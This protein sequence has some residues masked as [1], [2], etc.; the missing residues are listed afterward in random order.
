MAD[1]RENESLGSWIRRRRKA[2][3]LTQAVL[4]QRVGCAEVTIRKLEAEVT[5]P[6]RQI[7]ERLATCLEVPA[8]AHAHF[9][10][11]ARGERSVDDLPP[12]RMD[13]TITP[14]ASADVP[15]EHIPLDV[16][17]LPAPL[18]SGSRMPLRR[19]PL[20]VGRDGA[21][22][23]LARALT[24]SGT[25]AI[26][27]IEIAA[28]TG[29]GGIG[30]TQLACEFV[31]RYGPF[32]AG[33][34]FWLSFAD[35]AAV[36]AEVAACGGAEGMQLSADFGTLSLDTQVQQVL[37]AWASSTPR[38]LVFDNCEDEVLLEQWRPAH[39]G[40]RV[41]LTSRR[42][43]WDAALGVQPLPLDVLHR[44]ES[45]AL[46]CQFRPDL[47]DADADLSAIADALGDL[48]LALHLAGSFLAKYRHALTPA[49]YLAR[50]HAPTLLD[51][52]SLQA[53]GLSPT[54]H[55][56]HVARTFAQSYARLDPADPTDAIARM[57]LA[58]AAYVA[59]GEPIPRWFLLH[60][61]TSTDDPD[62]LLHVEDALTRLLDLGL[63]ETHHTDALRLHRLLVAFVRAVDHD[64]AARRAVQAT[65]L[66]VVA[67]RNQAGNPWSLMALQQHLR[68]IAAEPQEEDVFAA[69][70]Y[71]ALGRYIGLR[72][73]YA[74]AR[75]YIE[76]AVVIQEQLLGREHPDTA[77]S[78]RNLGEI[79]WRQGA[80]GE[81]RR[82]AEQ[83]IAIQEQ[84]LGRE[85]VDTAQSLYTLGWIHWYEGA[86]SEARRCAEQAV[87]IQ[88]RVLGNEHPA[89]AQSLACLGVVLEAQGQYA[90]AQHYLRRALVIQERVLGMEH[91]NT[92]QTL[93]SM[94]G[95][96][97][98]QGDYGQAAHCL[99]RA[100][101]IHQCVLG[102][103]HPATALTLICLGNLQYAQ[104][105]YAD[106][107]RC[108]EQSLAIRQRVLGGNHP[109]I[110][111]SLTKLGM[112]LE[113]KGRYAEAQDYYE[114]ALV[115]FQQVLGVDHPYTA[116]SLN[117]LGSVFESQK[118]YAEAQAYYEQGLAIMERVLGRNHPYTAS[119]L[120]NLGSVFESQKRYA[121]AQDYYEQA[122]AIRQ[123][124][125][126]IDHSDTMRSLRTLG[127]LL[128]AQGN[129]TQARYYLEQAL[130]VFEQRLGSQH[131]DTE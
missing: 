59:P 36:P 5:R 38:L 131:P 57:L 54:Q 68:F 24:M 37:T 100:L 63:L 67:D 109:L 71:S 28:A 56:Q 123:C 127:T 20:F 47:S 105:Q 114:Q 21:L 22:R 80:Y 94:G 30:K 88:E 122:L 49:Q 25:A 61:L 74:E 7:A 72:G 107:H 48:P 119:S 64:T 82:C 118:R 89:I 81:A 73:A 9:L 23:Q 45:V 12:A 6:S 11:V 111:E 53:A 35:P 3:D 31:H 93:I 2:L 106:A 76:R 50:L 84:V 97:T 52:R 13:R 116:S 19:N 129:E 65:M 41:L 77:Q 1:H 17:P 66:Q 120:N 79:L 121:E 58:R 62:A 95:V 15:V 101:E 32:F 70:L 125:L 75:R 91:P 60:T 78:L 46:L 14:S 34:V 99:K 85:H 98:S 130:A 102:T 33:G 43:H 26:G 92:A 83:A 113:A 90:E 44:A 115:L 27:Q 104:A 10:Q 8:D 124:V 29:L 96:A 55:V 110:A 18:P 103:D 117:N 51:D 69:G 87:T 108:Y 112:V 128:H 126:G 40:C 4:A 42:H 16:V 39:G 86:Y